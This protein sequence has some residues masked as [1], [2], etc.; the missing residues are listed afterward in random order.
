MIR[1][2]KLVDNA[3]PEPMPLELH[4]HQPA[5]S[6]ASA[7]RSRNLN[8][9]RVLGTHS[10]QSRISAPSLALEPISNVIGQCPEH[11]P[12]RLSKMSRHFARWDGWDRPSHPSSRS[13]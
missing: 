9:H 3:N 12:F 1:F 2:V 5:R 8:K 13:I 7:I 10:R 6:A 4:F 11:A